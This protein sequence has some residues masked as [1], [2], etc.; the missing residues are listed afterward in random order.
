M[1]I[2]SVDV[3]F[4]EVRGATERARRGTWREG[5]MT[6]IADRSAIVMLLRMINAQDVI[7]I[8]VNEGYTAACVLEEVGSSIRRYVGVDV[9][10]GYVTT[11][12]QQQREVPVRAGAAVRDNRF[13]LILRSSS[14][15]SLSDLGSCDAMIIDG[16]HSRCGVLNDT[17]L[18]RQC[19][20]ESG[21]IIWHD[22]CDAWD[23]D[24]RAVLEEMAAAGCA[25]QH[26]AGTRVAFMK[27]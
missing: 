10:P 18:A 11:L 7:E 26:V 9:L 14:E 15:L 22:C 20:R 24:V 5:W 21:M 4:I 17:A 27:V 3:P 12:P 1:L 19:V 2:E 16:D 23:N 25:I 13:I 8:G 6:S